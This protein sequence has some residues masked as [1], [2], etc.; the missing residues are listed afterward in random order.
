MRLLVTRPEPENARTAEALRAL[1]HD[2]VLAPLLRIEA[3]AGVEFGSGPWDAVLLTSGNAVR[4]L[5]THARHGEL[6]ALPLYAVGERSATAARD[7]GFA[8]AEAAGGDVAALAAHVAAKLP[9]GSRLLY[10][11]GED[12][13]G[14]LAGVLTDAGF[15]VDV[16]VTYRAVKETGLPDAVVR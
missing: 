11:A 7:A 9:Q 4:A 13:T 15:V 16:V 6:A 1:G 5:A 12:R 2:V 14:D 3:I 10:L 8:R